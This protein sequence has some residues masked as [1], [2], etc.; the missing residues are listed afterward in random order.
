MGEGISFDVGAIHMAGRNLFF[1]VAILLGFESAS[2]T[3]IVVLKTQ[4]EIIAAADSMSRFIGE[5]RP[6]V[7]T[8]CKIRPVHDFFIAVAGIYQTGSGKLNID[9]VERAPHKKAIHL[10][11]LLNVPSDAFPAL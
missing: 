9:R 3:T 1:L 5:A 2:A 7:Y 11:K 6:P 10:V 8:F 4:S